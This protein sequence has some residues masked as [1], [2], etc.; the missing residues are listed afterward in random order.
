MVITADVG[1]L[2]L[3]GETGVR[4]ALGLS[5]CFPKPHVRS[6]WFEWHPGL[7]ETLKLFL[8]EDERR[9]SDALPRV[10]AGK[11]VFSGVLKIINPRRASRGCARSVFSG[12]TTRRSLRS[13]DGNERAFSLPS[14]DASFPPRSHDSQSENAGTAGFNGAFLH[15]CGANLC[16]GASVPVFPGVSEPRRACVCGCEDWRCISLSSRFLFRWFFKWSDHS[17]ILLLRSIVHTSLKLFEFV[18]V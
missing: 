2:A 8:T 4:R 7:T 9:S 3:A 10:T 18:Y 14:H 17:M 12:V 5:R 15:V 6:G 11:R 16:L 13:H 1:P